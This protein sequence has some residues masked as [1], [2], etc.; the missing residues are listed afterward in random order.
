MGF[1]NRLFGRRAAPADEGLYFYVRCG[2]CGR[3]LRV[4]L[5]KRHDLLPDW[6]QGGYTLTKEMMDDRCFRLMRAEMTF[7]Q[8]Y[9]VKSQ[10]IEGGEFITQAEYEAQ[11]TG[12]ARRE[13]DS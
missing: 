7:D 2:N 3:A 5:D 6:D 1:L 11:T 9:V 12:A 10:T 13:A 8:N 4:R